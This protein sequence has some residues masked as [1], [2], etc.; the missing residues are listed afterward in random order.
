MARESQSRQTYMAFLQQV[1]GIFDGGVD[2][3]NPVNTVNLRYS[4]LE[5]LLKT[6]V[7]MSTGFARVRRFFFSFLV[8]LLFSYGLRRLFPA[9]NRYVDSKARHSDYRKFDDALRMTVD[10]S[11]HQLEE[12][13][14]ICAREAVAGRIYY[15][16]H[17]SDSAIMT[18]FVQ[19][20]KEGQHIH[21]IDGG[22]GGYAMAAKQ[23]KAQMK[24]GQEKDLAKP[25]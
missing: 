12:L 13:Q 14:A 7:R 6:D 11:S 18:C 16:I 2:S 3:A 21:F 17:V 1:D 4:K 23:L 5:T 19:S 20:V 24:K 9:L 15:G 22:S 8:T 25:A 10:C